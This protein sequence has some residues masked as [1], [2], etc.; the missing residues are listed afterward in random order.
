MTT[1]L[2]PVFCESAPAA[3]AS[4]SHAMKANNL[5]Y[6]SGQIPMTS[7]NKLVEGSIADKA[8]QV[9]QNI[10]D[11]LEASN[12]SLDRIIKVNIFLADIKNFAEFNTVY[13]KYFTT[14][15]PARSCVAV[16]ALP[17]GVDMEVEVVAAE[18]D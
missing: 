10:K 6:T 4:Y 15:K 9:I 8:E 17:L 12:S 18:R 1:K 11:V 3:A 2:T 16:A 13:A 5:I 14:H 7:D